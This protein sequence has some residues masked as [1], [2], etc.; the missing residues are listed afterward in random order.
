[1]LRTTYNPSNPNEIYVNEGMRQPVLFILSMIN[2]TEVDL[3]RRIDEI[4]Q[5]RRKNLLSTGGQDE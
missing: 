3:L 2:E 4:G 1:M 5:E